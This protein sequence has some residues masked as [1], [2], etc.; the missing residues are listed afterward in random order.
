M[1]TAASLI[2]YRHEL[3]DG[4]MPPG[5][6]DDLVRDAARLDIESRGLRIARSAT[7]TGDAV[8]QQGDRRAHAAEG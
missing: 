1:T 3:L 7:A 4:G 5:I 2:A 6:V 8:V